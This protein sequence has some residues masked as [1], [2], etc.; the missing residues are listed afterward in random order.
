MINY[1][2]LYCLIDPNTNKIRYIGYTT[3]TL[4]HR[5]KSHIASSKSNDKNTHRGK[6]I[7]KLSKENKIPIIKELVKVPFEKRKLLEIELIK[8]YKQFCKLTNG[9]KGGDGTEGYV[10]T[11]EVRKKM[12]LLQTG[13]PKPYLR[14]IIKLENI[15][16]KEVIIFSDKEEAAKYLK[17]KSQSIL[18]ASCGVRPSI[19]GW[20]AYSI[21]KEKGATKLA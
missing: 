14:N 5:L 19:C 8:H 7:T 4:E 6:W 10:Y 12:S 13:K 11:D 21:K 3:K 18:S 1:S 9:T 16:T 20:R 2:I 15:K 17:C